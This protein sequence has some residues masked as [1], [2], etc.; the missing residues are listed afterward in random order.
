MPASQ[1]DL[2][3]L[4]FPV[5][6]ADVLLHA[7]CG[8]GKAAGGCRSLG[9]REIRSTLAELRHRT[10]ILR[11]LIRSNDLSGWRQRP[12]G[13]GRGF[14]RR[15]V[16][17]VDDRIGIYGIILNIVAIFGCLV[18]GR[19]DRALGSKVVVLVSLM[20][21]ILATFGI[22]S[23]GVDFTLFGLVSLPITGT[24]GLFA[25]PAEKAYILYGLL[26]GMSF[27]PVQAS[28]RSYL[29]RSVELHEA[30]RY[31][32]IYSLSG[33]A[34]SFLATLS[35]SVVTA[36]SGSAAGRH[37]NLADLPDRRIADA[38]DDQISGHRPMTTE[39]AGGSLHRP[40]LCPNS[41]IFSG[42]SGERP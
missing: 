4:V 38:L 22:I 24:E 20:M 18:A 1:A 42:G 28:S 31:F 7:G 9:L 30:G 10:N 5:H 15:H 35:F 40:F 36:W 2:S 29:A 41:I 8:Q 32:G 17:L 37:G 14:R 39:T 27:G 11:F 6:P 26:I 34:T 16:R 21:L 19:V 13:P 3:G 23:T 33:R 12:A 25:T